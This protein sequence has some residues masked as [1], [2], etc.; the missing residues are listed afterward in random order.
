MKKDSRA[1][2]GRPNSPTGRL[3]DSP[4][5]RAKEEE[6]RRFHPGPDYGRKAA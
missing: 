1:M 3:A 4:E 6:I 5:F 2:W